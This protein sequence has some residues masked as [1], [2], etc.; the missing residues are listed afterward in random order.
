MFAV[1]KRMAH[2][3]VINSNYVLQRNFINFNKRQFTTS[4]TKNSKNDLKNVA[5]FWA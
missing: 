3:M 5:S 2:K 4:W 1:A